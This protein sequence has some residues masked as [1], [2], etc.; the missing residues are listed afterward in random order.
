[1]LS[2]GRKVEQIAGLLKNIKGIIIFW[3]LLYTSA[4]ATDQVLLC[5]SV[6]STVYYDLFV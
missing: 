6:F 5:S 4:L 1:M 2:V 3:F